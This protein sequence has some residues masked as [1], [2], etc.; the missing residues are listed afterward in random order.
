MEENSHNEREIQTFES[1]SGDP[2]KKKANERNQWMLWTRDI[3]VCLILVLL[4]R[5]NVAEA[6]YIPS[7]SMEPNLMV[8]DRII[9]DKLSKHWRPLQRGDMV[10]FHPPNDTRPNVYGDSHIDDSMNPERWIKRVIGLPGDTVEIIRGSG[11]YIN[12][13]RL[14]EPYL[15]D[16]Y[17]YSYPAITLSVDDPSTEVDENEYFMLGDNRANSKDSH[18]WGPLPEKNV[19]GRA[20]FRYWPLDSIGALKVGEEE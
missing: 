6:N 20:V 7:P 12:G 14:N 4:F 5:A 8:G 10:V 13:E 2:E 15:D 17:P 16:L 18:V 9:V 19:I 1:G 3:V 11:I